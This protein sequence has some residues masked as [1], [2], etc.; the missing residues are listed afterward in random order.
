[1]KFTERVSTA[2]PV[3]LSPLVEQFLSAS[4]DCGAILLS[5]LHSLKRFAS[6]DRQ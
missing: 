5:S 1:M 3:V 6:V 4:L 2:C